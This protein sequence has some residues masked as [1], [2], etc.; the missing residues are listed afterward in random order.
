MNEELEEYTVSV[1][2]K[3]D[4]A[5]PEDAVSQMVLWIEEA[6]RS[7]GYRW[8]SLRYEAPAW[9][10]ETGVIDSGGIDIMGYYEKA[11]EDAILVTLCEE[12]N[13]I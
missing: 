11:D 9:I 2:C 10:E 4:A 1:S 13:N 7:T 12:E 3:F 8:E 5:N 6:A